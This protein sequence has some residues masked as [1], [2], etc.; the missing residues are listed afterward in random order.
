MRDVRVLMEG[1]SRESFEMLDRQM[2]VLVSECMSGEPDVELPPDAPTS[3]LE[4]PPD[5]ASHELRI[6]DRPVFERR[7]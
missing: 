2:R 3:I 5:A 7:V 6:I 4:L 1:I